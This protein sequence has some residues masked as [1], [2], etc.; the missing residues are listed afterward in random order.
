MKKALCVGTLSALALL[1]TSL[2][3]NAQEQDAATQSITGVHVLHSFLGD[4]CSFAPDLD[5]G[6]CCGA[7]DE[8]YAIGGN[9]RDRLNADR[10]FRQC[11]I[12][13][14][15]PVVAGIYYFGV[16]LFGWAF[17]NWGGS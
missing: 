6:F 10:S 12:N 3:A 5:I 4:Q 11:I 16:R 17:F 15:R 8:E 1:G 9:R 7:H 2:P 13:E 14:G